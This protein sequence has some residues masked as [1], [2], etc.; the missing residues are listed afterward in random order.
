MIYLTPSIEIE[1]IEAEDII[2][3]SVTPPTTGGG[4]GGGNETGWVSDVGTI[5]GTTGGKITI[6]GGTTG[7][8][9]A[10]DLFG[11]R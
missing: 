9:S 4:L 6:G 8:F 7:G 2:L 5:G 10:G 3:T 11:N 1:K